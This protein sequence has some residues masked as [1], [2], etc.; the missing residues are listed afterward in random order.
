V[1][2]KPRFTVHWLFPLI[3][4]CLYS[5][6]TISPWGLALEQRLGLEVLFRWRGPEPAPQQVAVIAITKQSA[7]ALQLP[8]KFYEWSRA[9]HAAVVQQL[10]RL[11][12]SQIVFDVFFEAAHEQA[13]DGAFAA[14][15]ANQG[16]VL[17]FAR[18]EREQVDLGA[19]EYA[20][21]HA[22]KQPFA[23]FKQAALATAP[24]A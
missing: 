3:V 16:H 15:M 23:L 9:T 1:P 10:A 18:A 21:R 17:L 20:D 5:V 13:G 4:L 8:S 6:W 7:L 11:G 24:P 12:V 2:R 19:G 22:L 14:A